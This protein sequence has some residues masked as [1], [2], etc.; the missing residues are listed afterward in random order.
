MPETPNGQLADGSLR[1]WI[2]G[3]D[4]FPEGE[5][6]PIFSTPTREQIFLITASAS[7]SSRLAGAAEV[8]AILG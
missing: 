2:Y 7:I 3:K 5:S 1:C 6:V 8:I 4:P